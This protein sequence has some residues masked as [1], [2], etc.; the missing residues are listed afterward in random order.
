M[1]AFA[2]LPPPAD[3]NVLLAILAQ[4]ML[5]WPSD[6]K[7]R[8]PYHVGILKLNRPELL[9]RLRGVK[10]FDHLTMRQVSEHRRQILE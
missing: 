5:P 9:S 3:P 10:I 7:R 6:T 4:P 8:S 1:H 2:M